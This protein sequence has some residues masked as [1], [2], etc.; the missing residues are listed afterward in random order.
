MR[1]I[2]IV[3][4]AGCV[5]RL[6]LEV[7]APSA[8]V[9]ERRA[10]YRWN[11]IV[12]VA[13]SGRGGHVSRAV[14]GTGAIAH[15]DQLQPL[16]SPNGLTARAIDRY[17]ADEDRALHWMWAFEGVIVATMGAD[18]AMGLEVRDHPAA[19]VIGTSLVGLILAGLCIERITSASADSADEASIAYAHYNSEL[20][21]TLHLCTRDYALVDCP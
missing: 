4:C 7:P 19:F 20:R 2:A 12:D 17:D 13:S 16:V 15:P 21:E 3:L 9:A 18:V 14:L 11:R 10:A 6:P 1:A 5:A 8:P